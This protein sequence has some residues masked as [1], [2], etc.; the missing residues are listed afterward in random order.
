MNHQII[1]PTQSNIK[2]MCVIAE[3]IFGAEEDNTQ[4]K[5][6]VENTLSLIAIEKNNLVCIK[7]GEEIVA[8]TVVLPTSKENMD[9]FL[10]G[11]ITE[12]EL[13]IESKKNPLFEALYL[14]AAIT[15]PTYQRKGLAFDLIKYQI[16]YFKDKYNIQ[17]FYSLPFSENG[18]SL[19]EKISTDLS[20]VIKIPSN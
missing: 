11:K 4:T 13:S 17:N 16:E 19:M 5:P 8:W 7:D 6:T 9:N 18:M 3:E 1:H 10:A 2:K 12:K 20:M 15:L 14:M